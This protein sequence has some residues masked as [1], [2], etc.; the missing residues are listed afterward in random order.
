MA[1]P[2]LH[3]YK[4]R[5]SEAAEKLARKR[6]V[7]EL[8][9]A[10]SK[11][12][13]TTTSS[14]ACTTSENIMEEEE[15]EITHQSMLHTNTGFTT[16]S[17]ETTTT[18]TSSQTTTT[19]SSS[20]TTNDAQK[21]KTSTRSI[22]TQCTDL[23][24]KE[25]LKKITRLEKELAKKNRKKERDMLVI[26]TLKEKGHNPIAIKHVLQ[27]DMKHRNYSKEDIKQGLVLKCL[28]PKT[29]EYLRKNGILPLP[30]PRTLS[31]WIQSFSCKPGSDNGLMELLAK[32]MQLSDKSERQAIMLFDEMD[33][34]KVYEYDHINKQVYGGVKKMQCVLV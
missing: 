17:S 1:V 34:K 31:R 30:S 24:Y 4:A 23:R 25:A 19:T 27:P 22:G 12:T 16:T 33:I 15:I 13:T 2:T 9:E 8:L 21:V 18:T 11:A 5:T 29:F 7:E 10:D 28:S 20:Q 26:E 3:L 32:K 6:L 14:I